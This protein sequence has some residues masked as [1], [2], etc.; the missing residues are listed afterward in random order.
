MHSVF[1]VHA[2]GRPS[3]EHDDV[4]HAEHHD[5]GV[6]RDPLRA[7]GASLLVAGLVVGVGI[8][9]KPQ[10]GLVAVVMVATLLVV[11]PRWPL[12]SWWAAGGVACAVALAAPYVIWQQQHG[13]P[14]VTVAGETSPAARR[15]DGPGF[16][17]V[18]SSCWSARFWYRCGSRGCARRF[19]AGEGTSCASSR[20]ATWCWPCS[21]SLATATRTIS[22]RC[23]P[24]LLG[25]G[26]IPTTEWTLRGRARTP[27]LAVAI[28]LS[29]AV[30]A[31]IALPLLPERDL[32]GSVVMA[33]NPAPGGRNRRM[34]AVRSNRLD[35]L[36]SDTGRQAGAHRDLHRQL[37]RG[38]RDRHP[39]NGTAAPESLQR[40][41]RLQSV[42]NAAVVRYVR[43]ARRLQQRGRRSTLLRRVPKPSR[44]Q[45]R[46]RP[47]QRRGRGLPVMLCRTGPPW[48]ALWPHLRHY[49]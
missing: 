48:S 12:R 5:P 43:D 7:S 16:Y 17:S 31:W 23:I 35:G 27:W 14:Q 32:Q 6:P 40:S 34:V 26:A 8:E 42:G 20:S 24:V 9:A 3:G 49:N 13:W 37:R 15:A 30:R 41:Q 2:R 28:G 18:P 47:G 39:R 36:A 22:R 29:A 25:L 45:Q 38:W 11:G 19:D 44:G 33:L 1:G 46:A 21:T 10:V 4:R